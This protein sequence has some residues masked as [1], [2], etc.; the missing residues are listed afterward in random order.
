[1]ILGNYFTAYQYQKDRRK[2]GRERFTA[3]VA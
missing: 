2:F 3:G 1:L